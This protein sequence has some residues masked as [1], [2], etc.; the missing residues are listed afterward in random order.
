MFWVSAIISVV[1]GLLGVPLWRNWL[2]S[3]IQQA[4]DRAF[5]ITRTTLFIIEAMIAV[6]GYIQSGRE[7]ETL[8]RSLQTAHDSRRGCIISRGGQTAS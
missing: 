2:Q 6:A 5:D 8:R 4:T 7:N 1:A 3:R